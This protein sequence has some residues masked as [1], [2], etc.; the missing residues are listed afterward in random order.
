MNRTIK[1]LTLV[2][3]LSI[4]AACGGSD[5]EEA[6]GDESGEEGELDLGPAT[7]VSYLPLM[8]YI[9]DS[10]W[11]DDENSDVYLNYG[12]S[13]FINNFTINPVDSRTLA[14]VTDTEASDFSIT[15]DD[16]P[17]NPKVSF[18]L[19]QKI[20]G[21]QL[22]VRSAIIINTSG[23]MAGVDKDAFIQGI[24]N[25][26]I[27][28]KA[29]SDYYIA[30]QAY[31]V[32]GY[33]GT[34]VE[35]TTGAT[36]DLTDIN[37]AL[38]SVLAKWKTETYEAS[39][40]S[41]HT[42]DAIVEAI[43]RYNGPSEFTGAADLEFRDS[44]TAAA[45]DNDLIEYITPDYILASNVLLFSRGYGTPNNFGSA[46]AEKALTAQS[47][48]IY[49]PTSV[50]AGANTD[51]LLKAMP[52]IYVVPDDSSDLDDFLSSLAAST[53]NT[54]ISGG[55]YEFSDQ[56]IASQRSGL[57]QKDGL[58]N[59]HVLRW[60]SAI[61]SGEG[62]NVSVKTRTADDEYG[63]TLSYK[64]DLNPANLA[65]MPDP[66]VEITGANNEYIAANLI[67]SDYDSAI[68][69]A[70]LISNFYPATRWTNQVFD[71]AADY[72]WVATPPASITINADNSASIAS[73]ASYPITLTLT[74]NNIEHSGAT[75]TDSFTLTI[76]ESN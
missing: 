72:Q 52:L 19:L 58:S 30:N 22:A 65:A 50:G 18:P 55:K 20:I 57:G 35:E 15:E 67:S 47:T 23:A 5:L 3:L 59:Q 17:V 34:V 42:Y 7:K 31:T 48:K 13:P 51:T 32:W 11:Y 73:G 46:F 10:A 44:T 36:S 14:A 49:D 69:Y 68:T 8:T 24:K 21:N 43:G 45:D 53:I 74:N 54:G 71:V 66:Q 9:N 75:G 64:I 39:S 70:N 12:R 27:A 1:N 4:L 40:G 62:H 29:H 38:D 33:S 60:A 61:R 41:N 28:A 37:V 76:Y 16:L 2:T 63:F 25:Y 26:V 6:T 56:V